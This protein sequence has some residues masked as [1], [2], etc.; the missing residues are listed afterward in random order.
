MIR[1]VV[2]WKLTAEDPSEK[3]EVSQRIRTLLEDLRG[4]IPQI[5]QLEVSENAVISPA[6]WDLILIADYDSADDLEVY[7]RHPEHLRV[8]A[9]I[10]SLVAARSS[11]DFE[12]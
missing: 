2:S 10:N 8:A 3:H 7:L 5:K 11:V 9:V 4:P 12:A 1:H 6:N